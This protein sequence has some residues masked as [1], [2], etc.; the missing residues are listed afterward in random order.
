MTVITPVA[1]R[2]ALLNPDTAFTF[3]AFA[4]ATLSA[5]DL[6]YI[7]SST[8]RLVKTNAGASGTAKCAGMVLKSAAAGQVVTVIGRGWIGG[9]SPSGSY[10]SDL[11]ASDTAGAVDTAAGTV[12]LVV[13]KVMPLP[14]DYGTP[15]KI[16]YINAPNL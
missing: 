6:V 11:Y 3:N 14:D 12:S 15:T 13:G 2:V 9:F 1:D 10:Y 7:N 5:G 4:G 16:L 8:G